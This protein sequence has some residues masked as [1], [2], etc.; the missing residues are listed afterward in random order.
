MAHLEDHSDTVLF[1]QTQVGSR[2]KPIAGR[3]VAG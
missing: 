2:H 3:I 1:V